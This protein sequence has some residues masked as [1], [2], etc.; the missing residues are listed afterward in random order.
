[1]VMFLAALDQTIVAT[2]LP[3]IVGDLGG[4]EHLS[5]V[6]TAYLLAQTAVTPLYGKLGDLYGCKRVLQIGVSIFLLDSALCRLSESMGELIAFRAVQGLGGRGL[7][8]SAQ[9]AIGDVVPPRDRGRPAGRRPLTPAGE[10]ALE[11]LVATGRRRLAELLEGWEP[12]EHR[13]LGELSG[14]LARQF[15]IDPRGLPPVRA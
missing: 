9:A 15:F 6:V 11:Q 1:M 13:E 5:W 12:D 2:A 14:R 10:R 8:V 7:I 3:T 4:L